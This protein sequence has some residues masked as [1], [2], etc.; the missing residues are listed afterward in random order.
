MIF[1][2]L[3]LVV[4]PIHCKFFELTMTI[5]VHCIYKRKTHLHT[6]NLSNSFPN[7]G[8]SATSEFTITSR[9]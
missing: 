3:L 5:C 9:S 2:F 7:D 4:N 1:A 6:V 8:H